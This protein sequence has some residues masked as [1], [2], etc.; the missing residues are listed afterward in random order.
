MFLFE[1]L[2]GIATYMTILIFVCFLLTKTNLSLKATL[3]FY[4]LCLCIMA[5]FYKPYVTADLYRIYET[6]DYF[7]KMPFVEFWRRI[8]V[9][10]EKPAAYLLYWCIGKTGV[11]ALLPT[12]SAFVCYSLI[13]YVINKTSELF[14]ISMRNVACVLFFVMTTSIYISVIGGIR[15]MISISL[16]MFSYFRFI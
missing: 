15:M 10:S 4:L 1:R 2:F 14:A 5:F 8:I 12:F 3:R 16:I 6:T 13:F 11:K 9:G 7:T